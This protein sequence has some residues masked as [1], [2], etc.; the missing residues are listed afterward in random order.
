MQQSL[1]N[2]LRVDLCRMLETMFF[3]NYCQL[4]SKQPY[5]EEGTVPIDE[6]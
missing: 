4:I 1:G 3:R 5:N 2:F 6:P